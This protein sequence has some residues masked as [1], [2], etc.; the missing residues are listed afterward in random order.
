MLLLNTKI[1]LK[2]KIRPVL[3]FDS[4][5]NILLFGNTYLFYIFLLQI[6]LLYIV[7]I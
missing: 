6:T 3:L 5:V 4:I 1:L 7:Q 2:T